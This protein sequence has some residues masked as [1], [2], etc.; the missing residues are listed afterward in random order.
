MGG[1]NAE[2][3]CTLSNPICKSRQFSIPRVPQSCQVMMGEMRVP[4]SENSNRYVECAAEGHVGFCSLLVRSRCDWRANY[5]N[6]ICWLDGYIWQT[7][8]QQPNSGLWLSPQQII[9]LSNIGMK[10]KYF[11]RFYSRVHQNT[12]KFN[13][14][15]EFIRAQLFHQ[16]EK[17]LK[18]KKFKFN[19]HIYSLNKYSSR[20]SKIMWW[21]FCL[22]NNL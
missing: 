9:S 13:F 10:G 6:N 8:H 18:S 19:T 15:L 3:R 14:S 4:L 11:C 7:E 21:L 5:G 1:K 20:Q 16:R 17:I 2:Q 12:M 22:F